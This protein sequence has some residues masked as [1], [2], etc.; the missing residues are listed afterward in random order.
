MNDGAKRTRN[1]NIKGRGKVMKKG[2][3]LRPM[4]EVM[5]EFK[6]MEKERKAEINYVG[7]FVDIAFAIAVVAMII[8]LVLIGGNGVKI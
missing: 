3:Q 8:W 1:H 5:Q 2:A 6:D 4:S 7:L